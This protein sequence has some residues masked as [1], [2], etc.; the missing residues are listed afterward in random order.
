MTTVTGFATK[1]DLIELEHRIT[2]KLYQALLVQTFA[3]AGLVA[4]W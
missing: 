3:V 2:A 1:T 4:S